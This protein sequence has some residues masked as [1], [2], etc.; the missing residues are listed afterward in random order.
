VIAL[1]P[2]ASTRGRRQP[3]VA[4]DIH[5]PLHRGAVRFADARRNEPAISRNTRPER[6]FA[7]VDW[8]PVLRRSP[9]ETYRRIASRSAPEV[10]PRRGPG[11]CRGRRRETAARAGQPASSPVP[12]GMAPY[13]ITS[14]ARGPRVASLQHL[15]RP[16]LN[17]RAA[18]S[19]VR[20]EAKR[21]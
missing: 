12:D 6:G 13:W 16:A 3:M 18:V 15:T 11:A 20:C 19:R 14:S 9:V 10:S 21:H 5:Y 2:L 1:T 8:R 4:G 7:R 17:R